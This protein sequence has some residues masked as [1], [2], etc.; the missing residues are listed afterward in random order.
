MRTVDRTKKSNIKCEHCRFFSATGEVCLT[1]GKR[2]HYW[3][4][5]DDFEWERLKK[6]KEV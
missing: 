6:E 5:C 1:T 2:K 4:K 3:N